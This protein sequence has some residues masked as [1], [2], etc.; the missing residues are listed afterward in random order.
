MAVTSTRLPAGFGNAVFRQPIM[1]MVNGTFCV[2][3][4]SSPLFWR[5][6]AEI[7]PGLREF[8]GL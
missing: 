4:A 3:A 5:K 7:G 1:E 2:S 8:S 6:I